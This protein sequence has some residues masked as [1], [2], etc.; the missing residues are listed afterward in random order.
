LN[1]YIEAGADVVYAPKAATMANDL[2]KLR[3]AAQNLSA[4][5]LAQFNPPGFI[6]NYVPAGATDGRSI[7]DRSFQELFD[8]GVRIVN[9]PQLYAVAYKALG[10]VLGRIRRDGSLQ[11]ARAG[12]PSFAEILDLLGYERFRNP[13]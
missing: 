4:P 1:A 3:R 6:E 2:A 9:S 13:S 8:C 12:M 7:A 10:D 5:M 11:P